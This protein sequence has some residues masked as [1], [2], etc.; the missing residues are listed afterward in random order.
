MDQRGPNAIVLREALLVLTNEKY[1]EAAR[2]L[3]GP[4]AGRP[5]A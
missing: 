3:Y 5:H 1:R 2:S 4:Y